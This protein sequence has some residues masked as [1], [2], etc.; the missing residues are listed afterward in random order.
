MGGRHDHIRRGRV[1]HASFTIAT[2]IPITTNTTIAACVQIQVGDIADNSILCPMT[3]RPRPHARGRL[4]RSI[5]TLMIGLCATV[6]LALAAAAL[7]GASARGASA[8]SARGGT[9]ARASFTGGAHSSTIAPL[10]GVNIANLGYGSPLAQADRAIAYARTLHVRI[11]RNEVPWA[12]LE[13]RGPGQVDPHALAFLDRLL[14]DAAASGIGV[15]M[16]VDSTPCWASSAPSA[17]LRSCT[18]GRASKANAW[19]PREPA[20]YAAFVGYLAARYGP[21]LAAIE[22]WNEPDQANQHY[23]AGPDK[24]QR[25]A[26]ILR[27]AYP[28]INQAAPNVPVLGGSLVGSNGV[29]LRALYAAGIKGY[30]DGLAVHFYNLVLGS[31]RA[32]HE[33]QLANGDPKPMW[34]DE[35]GWSSCWPRQRV[36]QEQGCVTK[37]VQAENLANT[38]RSLAHTPYVAAEIVYQLQGSLAEEFGVLDPNGAHKPAFSALSHVLLSPLSPPASV[39]LNLRRRHSRVVASGS[40]PAGD[41]MDLEAYQGNVLRYKALFTLDRFNRYAFAL[42]QVLGSRGL[43]VRVFQF[44]AGSGRAAQRSI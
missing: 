30:Y 35:F 2:I 1:A 15:I 22:I 4:R 8:R 3:G 26:A 42:P 38:F 33:V 27:A 7:A 12:V 11:V 19:P 34:L 25:Y 32:M 28:A 6:A 37:Q 14:S 36:Q 18:P 44:W 23:F 13:P 39:T 41:Y 31:L 20:S 24:P 43:R 40:G 10:G 17:L 29:F 5:A 21:Q 9:L 16:T